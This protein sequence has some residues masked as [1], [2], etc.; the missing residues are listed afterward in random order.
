MGKEISR[1]TKKMKYNPKTNRRNFP[2]RCSGIWCYYFA[3]TS[4]WNAW[5]RSF[6]PFVWNLFLSRKKNESKSEYTRKMTRNRNEW[7]QGIRIQ[8]MMMMNNEIK[9]E[10]MTQMLVMNNNEDDSDDDDKKLNQ[11]RGWQQPTPTN[12]LSIKTNIR[13]TCSAAPKARIPKAVRKH[14]VIKRLIKL[15]Y[16]ASYREGE[17]RIQ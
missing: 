8:M 15:S 16:S 4:S 3:Q 11:R 12:P 17:V 10:V 14:Q 1:T 9:R 7:R 6:S 13:T 5:K 2:N